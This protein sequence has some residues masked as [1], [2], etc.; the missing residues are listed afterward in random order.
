MK[1][2]WYEQREGKFDKF[3]TRL[4][5]R[6]LEKHHGVKIFAPGKRKRHFRDIKNWFEKFKTGRL[7]TNSWSETFL[8][9]MR[10]FVGIIRTEPRTF[11]KLLLLLLSV[12]FRYSKTKYALN[13]ITMGFRLTWS[14]MLVRIWENSAKAPRM[15]GIEI[16]DS[17]G[18]HVKFLEK[19]A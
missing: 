11:E 2:P 12:R 9:E 1:S 15:R 8:V 19:T 17:S 14:L 16:A 13:K 5:H 18:Y 4:F 6:D 10:E 7:K 3:S